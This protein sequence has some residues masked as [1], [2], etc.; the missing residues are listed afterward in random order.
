METIFNSNNDSEQQYV[1]SNFYFLLWDPPLRDWGGMTQ[2]SQVNSWLICLNWGNVLPQPWVK[3]GQRALPLTSATLISNCSL[4]T[5]SSSLCCTSSPLT[6][7][8]R[9][10][11]SKYL[12]LWRYFVSASLSEDPLLASVEG[13]NIQFSSIGLLQHTGCLI[14][15]T[16]CWKLNITL[17]EIKWK[18]LFEF[19]VLRQAT[20]AMNRLLKGRLSD[21]VDAEC[22]HS[23]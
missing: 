19:T 22:K 1:M 15:K 18:C 10:F 3:T 2:G 20:M 11:I 8:S 7:W 9:S 13:D 6:S 16:I 21:D 14:K 23:W 12:R 17:G 4:A 5:H